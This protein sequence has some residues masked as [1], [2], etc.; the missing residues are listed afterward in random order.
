MALLLLGV[1]SVFAEGE[2]KRRSPR[3]AAYSSVDPSFVRER[4]PDGQ[5]KPITYAFG[6]GELM[7]PTERDKSLNELSFRELGAILAEALLTENY[8]PTPGPEETDLAIVV[9]WG[10]T[11]PYDNGMDGLGMMGMAET[12]NRLNAINQ[13]IAQN[14]IAGTSRTVDGIDSSRSERDSIV[15]EMISMT[16]MNEMFETRRRRSNYSN[17]KLLGY[18][19][20]LQDLYS[21]E[22]AAGPQKSL[23]LD[24]EAEIES[25]RYFVILQA[26]DFQKMWKEKKRKLLWVTRISIRAKGRDFDEE[27]GDMVMAASALF[28]RESDKLRRNLIPGKVRMGEVEVISVVD[29]DEP[30]KD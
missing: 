15:S 3:T 26:F 9:S 18:A 23:L 6:R 8:V 21:F 4:L 24:L 10:K 25:D 13:T 22:V 1:A 29:E 5:W 11:V 19:P 27:V 2:K 17:A 28:G 12:A 7:D 14:D 16:M 20:S 30:D